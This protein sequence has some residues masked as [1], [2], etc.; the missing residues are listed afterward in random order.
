[1]KLIKKIPTKTFRP[2]EAVPCSGVYLVFHRD[3][4]G[5][6]REVVL[7]SR[8]RFPAC[9]VCQDAVRFELAHDAPYIYDDNDFRKQT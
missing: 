3:D 7:L 5:G 8:D 1:M 2:G 9:T 4:H 6:E